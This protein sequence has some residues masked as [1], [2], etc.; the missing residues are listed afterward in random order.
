MTPF[1]LLVSAQAPCSSTMVGLGPPLAAPRVVVRAEAV[2][3]RGMIRAAMTMTNAGIT[4]RSLARFAVRAMFTVI[5]HF[6]RCRA[7]IRSHGKVLKEVTYFDCAAGNWQ[8]GIRTVT[9]LLSKTME[10]KFAIALRAD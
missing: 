2:W 5:L 6:R 4:R 1:Q 9:A 10:N 3:L 7:S 8:W